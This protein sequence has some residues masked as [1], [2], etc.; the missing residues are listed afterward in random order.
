MTHLCLTFNQM[1]MRRNP[2]PA[3]MT[4]PANDRGDSPTG[5]IDAPGEPA[6]KR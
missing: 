6:R 2:E 3:S 5:M 4:L 1:H